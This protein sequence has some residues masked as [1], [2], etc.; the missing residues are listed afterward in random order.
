MR[1][2]RKQ[3]LTITAAIAVCLAVCTLPV[4]VRAAALVETVVTD[5][6]SGI[7]I[8]GYDPV[9]YFI[10]GTPQQGLPDFEYQWQGVPWY[11]VSAANRDVFIR[12]PE[13]YAPRYGGH[14][15]TSLSRGYLSDGKPRLFLI[16][17][18]KLYF[19]YSVAN[20]D[21]FLQSEQASVRQASNN[22]VTLQAG[23]TGEEKSVADSVGDSA[24]ATA[25]P[26]DGETAPPH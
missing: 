22:W 21:A 1:Q 26:K 24:E 19:F 14:C 25:V 9:T 3:I 18:M 11:F 10:D 2:K 7:A 20:R 15:V 16:R 6:I 4:A 23:L 8:D 17:A 5:P 13:I 12:N